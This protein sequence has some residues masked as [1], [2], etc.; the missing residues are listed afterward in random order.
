[1][2]Q[3]LSWERNSSS[4]TQEI[5]RILWKFQVYYIIHKSTP[6]VPV[7]RQINSVHAED[8]F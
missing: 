2:E 1:M 4:A 8:P 5:C 6:P 7:L 3:S